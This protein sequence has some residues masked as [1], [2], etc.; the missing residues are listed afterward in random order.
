VTQTNGAAVSRSTFV[1]RAVPMHDAAG[2]SCAQPLRPASWTGRGA[3]ATTTSSAA[4]SNKRMQLTGRGG[5]V[6][7]ASRANLH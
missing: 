2:G 1:E 7:R 3:W 5:L 4:G 6:R